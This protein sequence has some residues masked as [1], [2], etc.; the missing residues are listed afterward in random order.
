MNFWIAL[1]VVVIGFVFGWCA[2]SLQFGRDKECAN[3]DHEQ[4]D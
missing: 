4:D 2:R 1:I 3:P